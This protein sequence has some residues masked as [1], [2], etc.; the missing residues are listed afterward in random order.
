MMSDFQVLG[1]V[2]VAT[3]KGVSEISLLAV[4]PDF[5]NKG[6]GKRYM[7]LLLE[8]EDSFS[9]K[10]SHGVTP[11]RGNFSQLFVRGFADLKTDGL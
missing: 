2:H 9:G 6:L 7:I 3:H 8:S 4:H 11:R 5:R 1:C 10:N